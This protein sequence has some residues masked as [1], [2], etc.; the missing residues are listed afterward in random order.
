MKLSPYQVL[1]RPVITEDS[2]RIATLREPQYSFLV[3][4]QAN[5]IAIARAIEEAFNVRVKSVNTLRQRGK[6]KRMRGHL[7][8]RPECKKAFVTLEEGN[9]IDLY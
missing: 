9:T 8:R 5:K 7:G 3:N 2:T 1:I 4:V 6:P